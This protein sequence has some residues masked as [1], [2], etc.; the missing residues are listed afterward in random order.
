MGIAAGLGDVTGLVRDPG[1]GSKVRVDGE[2]SRVTLDIDPTTPLL[3]VLLNHLDLKGSRYGRGLQQCGARRVLID[4]ELTYACAR[5]TG[6]AADQAITAR[7]SAQLP[8][9]AKPDWRS[10]QLRV[11]EQCELQVR[12]APRHAGHPQRSAGHSDRHQPGLDGHHADDP[13]ADL[14][15]IATAG[16]YRA[17]RHRPDII[18]RLPRAGKRSA[19]HP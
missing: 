18:L 8:L 4:G 2:R 3:D 16:A 19:F 5:E 14:A 13:A 17:V 7:I 10:L 12:P 15:A 6:S 9:M 11:L 1:K